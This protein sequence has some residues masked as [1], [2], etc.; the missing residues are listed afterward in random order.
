[1]GAGVV[2]A[3]VYLP[4]AGAH[5]S[6][7]RSLFKVLPLLSFAA[8]SYLVGAPLILTG[9]L[10]LSALGDYFL[11]RPAERAFLAGLSAFA[12]AHV[13]YMVV[14]V[15]LSGQIPWAAFAPSPVPAVLVAALALSVEL[16]LVPHTGA[17]RWPVRVYVL[18]ICGMMLAALVLPS[19]HRFAT[20]GAGAFVA[21][22]MILA[23]D[24][25]RMARENPWKGPAGWAIWGL[26]VAG[27]ALIVLGAAG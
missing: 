25:F 11:S 14:F 15:R 24:R 27:Q 1:M 4:L 5:P 17:L 6:A 19:A 7:R 16:W 2:A 18:L 9:G 13:A 26:Y 21:S 12:L 23:L 10:L 3:L 20:I 22:D 8:V